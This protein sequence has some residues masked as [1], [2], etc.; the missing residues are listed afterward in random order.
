MHEIHSVETNEQKPTR[1]FDK[2]EFSNSANE[3]KNY[4]FEEK[5]TTSNGLNNVN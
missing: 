2:I 1:R 5:K 3:I 4:T